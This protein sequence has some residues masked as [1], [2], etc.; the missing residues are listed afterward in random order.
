MG[1]NIGDLLRDSTQ[2]LAD[3]G[4]STARL[5]VLILLE[6]LTGKD[7]S[8]LLAHPE[9]EL[10]ARIIARLNK[11]I[12]RRTDHIPL[13]YIRGKASFY[14]RDF[15]VNNKVLVPRPETE[16]IITFFKELGLSGYIKVADVGTGSGCIGI[17]AAL[18]IPDVEAY[19]YDI[20]QDALKVAAVNAAAHH[21]S[22]H[23][24]QQDLLEGCSES[25]DV[26]L[27]NLPYVPTIQ[28]INKAAGHEPKLALFSGEDGLDH[29]RTFFE[30]LATL[31]ALPSII[32]IESEPEQHGYLMQLA[33]SKGYT[34]KKGEGFIQL[35]AL[36]VGGDKKSIPILPVR[37]LA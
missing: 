18:E 11:Y 14:G 13:A 9:M 8:L 29:Y 3:A 31:P 36:S 15:A 32:I 5:D 6:D 34:L 26:I 35:F 30:Q 16:T 7:R 23:I 21:V 22:V 20:S 37:R 17:T 12:T 2:T 19:L 1:R 27:A 33:A 10:P 4:I 25:F 24:K 28:R